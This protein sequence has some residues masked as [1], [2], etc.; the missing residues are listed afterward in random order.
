MSVLTDRIN[1]FEHYE[2]TFSTW[3]ASE[4]IV[5]DKK[6]FWCLKK[7]GSEYAKVCLYRD[8]C[9]MFVYGDYGQFTFDTMTW[10]GTVYNLQYD[11]IGY[12]MEKLSIESRMA[13]YCYDDS[14]CREDIIEWMFDRI[15]NR[16]YNIDLSDSI[17]DGIKNLMDKWLLDS[18]DINEFCD[19]NGCSDLYELLDFTNDLLSNTDEYE[20]IAHLRSVSDKL[21]DFDEACESSLWNAGKRIN[22]RY[23]ICMY[24]LQVCGQKLESM[25]N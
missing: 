6:A 3:E 11:N 7:P 25:K 4:Q 20:W 19:E 13:L 9:N 23:F 17:I 24:A 15:D 1:G 14:K 2:K 12:Q 10:L 5:D 16:Y 21:Q 8:G 22:Q 18:H